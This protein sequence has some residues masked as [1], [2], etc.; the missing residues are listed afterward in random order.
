MQIL[1]VLCRNTSLFF[2][3]SAIFVSIMEDIRK[4]IFITKN[5][6][7]SLNSNGIGSGNEVPFYFKFILWLSTIPS[8]S[9]SSSGP[10]YNNIVWFVNFNSLWCCKYNSNPMY[11]FE[12]DLK[13]KR[14]CHLEWISLVETPNV[15][16]LKH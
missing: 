2:P 8:S 5:I 1:N 12:L 4:R 10:K 11:W 14:N 9:H 13:Y 15:A 7:T 6:V 16:L 3:Y